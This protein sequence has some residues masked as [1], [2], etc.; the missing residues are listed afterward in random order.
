MTI[1]EEIMQ[2]AYGAGEIMRSAPPAVD[3]A[4]SKTG[5]ANY[6]TEYDSRVQEYLL[7]RLSAVLPEANFVGE[8]NG[9]EVFREEYAKGY[10]FVV[11]PIDGTSN[12]MKAYRPSVTSIALLKD[13]KP[14]IGVIYNPYTDQMFHAQAGCGAYEND[15]RIFSSE[16][17]LSDSLVSM[18]TA[19]YYEEE[20]SRSAFLLGHWYLLRSIDIRRSGSAAW[21][22]CMVAAGHIGLFFEPRLCLWDFAAGACILQEAGGSITAMDGTELNWRTSSSILAVSRGAAAGD[23]LP[24]RELMAGKPL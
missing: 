7:Q 17:P 2:A 9:K 19:P 24:P 23:Y 3:Y 12:F 5:H 15:S 18:G 20:V 22:I 16:A 13:G 6:V 21:D 8:E 10:T 14:W 4:G 1:K 11:D